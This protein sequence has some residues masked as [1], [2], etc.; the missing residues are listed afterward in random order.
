VAAV[1]A[2]CDGGHPLETLCKS[3]SSCS[4]QILRAFE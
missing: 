1:A 3:V 2:I 4:A